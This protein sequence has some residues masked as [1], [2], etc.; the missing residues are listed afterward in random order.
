MCECHYR[1]SNDNAEEA[2]SEH[3][4]NALAGNALAYLYGLLRTF[5]PG[6]AILSLF[7]RVHHCVL[8]AESAVSGGTTGSVG[9][10]G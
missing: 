8:V 2:E 7:F 4:A 6:G 9:G 1:K 10:M 5:A 3:I